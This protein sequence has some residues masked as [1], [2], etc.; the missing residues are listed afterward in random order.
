M[1]SLPACMLYC[2]CTVPLSGTTE[3]RAEMS[4]LQVFLSHSSQDKAAA[5]QF[6]HVFRQAGADIWHDEENLGVG[7]LRSTVM[8]ELSDRPI[9]VVLLSSLALSSSW[10]LGEVLLV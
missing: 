6:A 9:F 3:G 4:Q 8:K 10:V 5:D 7:H 2:D 1:E